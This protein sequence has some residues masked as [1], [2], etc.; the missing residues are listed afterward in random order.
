MKIT[1]LK[2][3]N[4]RNWTEASFEF[5]GRVVIYGDNAQGKTNILEAIYFVATTKSFRGRDQEAI[6]IGSE[7]AKIEAKIENETKSDVEIKF[8]RAERKIEKEF[9]INDKPRPSIDFIGEF[10]TVV[11]SPDDLLLVSGPPEAKRRYLSFTL[12]QVD[13]EYLYEL[14]NYKRVLRQRNELLKRAGM[15]KIEQE[16]NVWDENLA[17]Y[18]QKIIEKRRNLELFINER[19]SDYYSLISGG[20]RSL[21]FFYEPA[22]LSESLLDS[23]AASRERD[24]FD[25]YTNV[26]PHRDSWKFI[27]DGK[28][29]THFSSRGEYRTAILALKLV[30]RDFFTEKK[31]DTPVILLDDVF[32][33]LDESRRKLLVD[34]FSGCQLIITTTDLDHLDASYRKDTQMIE[35]PITA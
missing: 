2:L 3:T 34:A 15:V 24:L 25:K 1:N 4:F 10:S 31:N 26:G 35:I 22:L 32:S 21:K 16:I 8:I 12:G 29:M 7:F 23:L 33:E 17:D 6:R 14:L 11:F 13:R 19:L 28:E 20:Q 9:K 27:M 5:D 18:G 30:E